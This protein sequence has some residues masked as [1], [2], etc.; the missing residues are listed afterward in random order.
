M[1]AWVRGYL[2]H[3]GSKPGVSPAVEVPG[4]SSLCAGDGVLVQRLRPIQALSS[5]LH[6]DPPQPHKDEPGD[7]GVDVGQDVSCLGCIAWGRGRGG[8]ERTGEGRGG[9]GRGGEAVFLTLAVYGAGY[10][11]SR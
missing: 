1:K 8:E 10:E 9:E 7:Q 2:A 6:P 11:S 3:L 4:F 5:H